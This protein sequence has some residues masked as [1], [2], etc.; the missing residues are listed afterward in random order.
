MSGRVVVRSGTGRLHVATL[1]EGVGY[2]GVCRSLIVRP[3]GVEAL[4]AVQ[5]AILQAAAPGSVCHY[6]ALI[7]AEVERAVEVASLEQAVRA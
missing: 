5:A 7:A 3:R 6:C 2:L 1:L 4:D